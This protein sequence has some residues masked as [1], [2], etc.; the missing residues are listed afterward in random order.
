MRNFFGAYTASRQ[1]EPVTAS[2]LIFDKS[3]SIGFREETG[4][5]HTYH[6]EVNQL[7]AQ[8]ESFSG[9]SLLRNTATGEE[10]RITG[11]EAATLVKEMQ[12][13]IAKPWYRKKN[14]GYKGRVFLFMSGF[15]LVLLL[16]YFLFVPMI[17]EKMAGTIEPETER[18]LGDAVWESMAAGMRED[19][20]TSRLINDFFSALDVESEYRIRIS[21]I[22]DD[23]VNAFAL[24]GGR[25]VVYSGL[26]NRIQSYP[27]LAALL[28]HE[29]THV[30]NRH[31]TKSVFRRLGSKVFL[32]LIFGKMG[33]LTTVLVNHAD[34]LKSLTYSRQL[35]KEADLEGLSILT[36]RRIDPKGFTHLFRHLKSAARPNVMPELLASHP[37]IDKRMEYINEMS[38]QATV[39]TRA[40][41]TAIFQELKKQ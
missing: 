11:P 39:E 36:N 9:E 19:T 12:E 8:F 30:N 20:T 7:S 3:I 1:A 16:F 25:I 38:K 35:E 13:E 15:L 2:V 17:S 41:L 40:D 31:A 5:N 28:S 34:D 29:F 23:V 6:W 24:P 4:V 22:N 26:L 32:S 33:S 14:A 27:E 21:V 37:D 10:L 18:Q